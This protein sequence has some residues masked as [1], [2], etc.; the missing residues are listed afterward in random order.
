M[1][2]DPLRGRRKRR[3]PKT[4]QTKRPRRRRKNQRGN[5]FRCPYLVEG[6]VGVRVTIDEARRAVVSP[7][8]KKRELQRWG[9]LGTRRKRHHP[10]RTAFRSYRSGNK[11]GMD[12]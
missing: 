8:P 11:I 9:T 3:T 10:P 2:F 4:L 7:P 1:C 12:P 5:P 6:A